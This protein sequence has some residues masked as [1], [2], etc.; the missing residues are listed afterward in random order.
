VSKQ[1]SWGSSGGGL[2]RSANGSEIVGLMERRQ[3]NKRFQLVQQFHIHADHLCVKLA[4]VRH[5]VSDA[6]QPA[7]IL[8]FGHIAVIRRD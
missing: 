3:R 5:P 4:T 1:A 8:F 7:A 2:Q 6:D